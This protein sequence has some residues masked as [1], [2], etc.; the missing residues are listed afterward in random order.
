MGGREQTKLRARDPP[1]PL[2]PCYK[3]GQDAFETAEAAA[4]RAALANDDMVVDTIKRFWSNFSLS[5]HNEASHDE[6]VRVQLLITRYTLGVF[7]CS[8]AIEAAEAA[9]Q[10]DSKHADGATFAAFKAFLFGIADRWTDVIDAAAYAGFINT[11][12]QRLLEAEPPSTGRLMAYRMIQIH[13][14][15]ED[16]VDVPEESAAASWALLEDIYPYFLYD[17]EQW[18][19]ATAAMPSLAEYEGLSAREV[20]DAIDALK[21]ADTTSGD[22]ICPSF[23]SRMEGVSLLHQ[24]AT[25]TSVAM[26]QE[27][28]KGAPRLS[29][30]L[31]LARIGEVSAAASGAFSGF[32]VPALGGGDR[33]YNK[34]AADKY[35]RFEEAAVAPPKVWVLG[36]VG[37]PELAAA[38]ADALGLI[39]V[40]T[41]SAVAYCMDQGI[42]LGIEQPAA[43]ISAE[44][45]EL[46]NS[47][48][49]AESTAKDD[50]GKVAAAEVTTTP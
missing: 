9:W 23:A 4:A 12:L 41:A 5:P 26:L 38:L 44:E 28:P 46:I 43:E 50:D 35:D 42:D 30:S 24:R 3:R 32:T 10:R 20:E 27:L 13:A 6:Y 7:E 25:G 15:V 2:L 14:G 11:M 1:G 22:R 39:D 16:T 18:A 33:R 19:V 49:S 40:S 45:L 34:D 8:A 47:V 29:A 37:G 48:F 17:D 31:T 21:D 36:K